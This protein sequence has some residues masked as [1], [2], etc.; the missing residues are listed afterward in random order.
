[1][2]L[3]LKLINH[4]EIPR[5]MKIIPGKM[6]VLKINFSLVMLWKEIILFLASVNKIN[7]EIK[8]LL[9]IKMIKM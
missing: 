2:S 1:M 9:N 6:Y 8:N 3:S 7:V 5:I 4:S